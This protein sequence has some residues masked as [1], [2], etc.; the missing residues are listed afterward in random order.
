VAKKAKVPM[1]LTTPPEFLLSTTSSYTQNGA[2]DVYLLGREGT[3][4]RNAAVSRLAAKILIEAA[5]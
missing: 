5:S 4:V 1:L 2:E 3:A